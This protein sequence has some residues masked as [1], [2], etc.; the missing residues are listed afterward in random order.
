VERYTLQAW[1]GSGGGGGGAWTTLARGTT[2]GHKKLDRFPAVTSSRV[3][4][5]IDAALDTPCLA[6]LALYR[7]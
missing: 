6:N 4:L 3:R 1:T 7:S 5:A 2:I